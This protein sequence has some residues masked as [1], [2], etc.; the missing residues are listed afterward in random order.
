MYCTGMILLGHL[1]FIYLF[2]FQL[3]RY[4]IQ[5]EKDPTHKKIGIFA[6]M[7]RITDAL[8]FNW[9]TSPLKVFVTTRIQTH[10][11]RN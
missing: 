3:H 4:L 6:R 10:A 8:Q 2:G 11:V 1:L 5:V 9:K 7:D